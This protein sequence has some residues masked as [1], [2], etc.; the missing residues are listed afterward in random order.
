MCVCMYC[1]CVR[2]RECVLHEA[3]LHSQHADLAG[4]RGGE[5]ADGK[6]GEPKLAEERILHPEPE[7]DVGDDFQLVPIHI[8]IYISR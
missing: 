8:Y 4:N 7:V 5:Q 3:H 2:T 1:V 6:G